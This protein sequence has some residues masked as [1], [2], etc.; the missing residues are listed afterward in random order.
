M[1][2]LHICN[3]NFEWELSQENPPPLAHAFDQHP[4]FLQLQFLPVLYA[5]P[6]DGVLVTCTPPS[7]FVTECHLHHISNNPFSAYDQ[8]D[9]WG[10][11]LKILE[12]A[13]KKNIPYF[14][15]SWDIVK[16]VNSKVFSFEA[17]PLPGGRLL[18]NEDDLKEW[19]NTQKKEAVLKTSFGASGRGHYFFN[20]ETGID[21][22]QILLFAN[23]EWKEKRALIGEP[24]M[25]RLLDFSTQWEISKSKEIKKLGTTLCTNDVKG[26]HQ[27]NEVGD[28]SSIFGNHLE[29]IKEHD[30]FVEKVL[31]KIADVGYFGN[32]GIDAM[33]YEK[34]DRT[35]HLHPIVEINARKTMGWAALEIR[36]RHFPGKQLRL[37][38][39]KSDKKGPLPSYA[40]TQNGSKIIFPKQL[41]V[42]I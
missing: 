3:T 21:W 5:P 19:M 26:R 2:I 15:P 10:Y 41:Q 8:I 28:L 17:C 4:V 42:I 39:I 13:K 20:A 35:V 36:K 12:W 32:V 22:P 34:E 25:K 1:P 18:Y 38:Y 31:L 7:D 11:S 24:W 27:S 37:S 16:M 23:K 40:T 6:E 14:M 29:K 30:H 33:I 9:S